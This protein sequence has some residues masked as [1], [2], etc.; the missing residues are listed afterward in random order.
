MNNPE[1]DYERSFRSSSLAQS[2]RQDPTIEYHTSAR[3]SE[4]RGTGQSKRDVDEHCIMEDLRM[5]VPL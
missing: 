5:D 4:V 3:V 1:R 2:L